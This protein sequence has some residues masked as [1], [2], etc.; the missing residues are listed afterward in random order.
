M[1]PLAQLDAAND[2]SRPHAAESPRFGSIAAYL[3][4]PLW[5]VQAPIWLVAPKVQEA[6]A[7]FTITKP[8]LFLLFWLSIA[9][10]VAFSAASAARI[11]RAVQ[12][13][14]SP[15]SR[16]AKILATIALGLAAAATITIVAAVV[17]SLQVVA[18]GVMTMLL[19]AA[20]LILALSLSLSAFLSWRVHRVARPT[21]TLV[22]IVAAATIA[23]IAAISASGS[24]S[25][26]GLY[27]AVAVAV[28][29]AVV[30][31][32]W[33]RSSGIGR[34]HAARATT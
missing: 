34:T 9:G 26:I 31:F 22:T 29:N 1:S 20:M 15:V 32:S 27:V 5:A 14:G 19:N 28:L 24:G 4:A 8:L 18:L 16:W 6:T 7:P 2:R 25:A 13:L 11:P 17:P 10:A 21:S 12:G 33:G 30:W 3:A 23:M